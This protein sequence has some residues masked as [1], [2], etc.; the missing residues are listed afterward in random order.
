MSLLAQGNLRH[1]AQAKEVW[2]EAPMWCL[3]TPRGWAVGPRTWS[4][5]PSALLC[6]PQ[7]PVWDK[8][9]QGWLKAGPTG[10]QSPWGYGPFWLLM[11]HSCYFFFFK[12]PF[13]KYNLHIVKFTLFWV[14]SSVK[15]YKLTQLHNHYHERGTEHFPYSRKF[16]VP[17]CS[18]SLSP[19]PAADNY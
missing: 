2:E 11:S 18:Q 16:P 17:S 8:L 14:Y 7:V 19:P 10:S 15:F 12:L 4:T 1:W 13:W 3:D 6:I 9:R 5:R